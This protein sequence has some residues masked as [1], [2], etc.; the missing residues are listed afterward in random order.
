M[1]GYNLIPHMSIRERGRELFNQS[2]ILP[3][4]NTLDLSSYVSSW[5]KML[6]PQSVNPVVANGIDD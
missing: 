5:Y 2:I 1:W 4:I 3:G 6:M